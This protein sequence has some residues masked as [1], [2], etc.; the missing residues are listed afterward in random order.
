MKCSHLTFHAYGD[1][2][3]WYY[4][5]LETS[6]IKPA[7]IYEELSSDFEELTELVPGEYE[8]RIIW[9]FGYGDGT[10]L[11]KSA[12]LVIIEL[13][14][15]FVIFGYSY[16]NLA[17]GESDAYEGCYNGMNDKQFS[18]YTQKRIVQYKLVNV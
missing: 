15:S 17:K 2:P 5:R 10:V 14:G 16:Y 12:R 11:P 18:E 6:N 13:K 4:F 8:E 7:G 3:Q 9:E 1:D